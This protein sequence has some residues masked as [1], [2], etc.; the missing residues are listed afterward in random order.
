MTVRNYISSA[1]LTAEKLA[2]STRNHWP[3]GRKLGWRPKEDTS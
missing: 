2:I 3:A 1:E